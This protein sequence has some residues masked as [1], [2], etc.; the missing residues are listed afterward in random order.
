MAQNQAYQED[1]WQGIV[2][3]QWPPKII[4]LVEV[5][6][7][8]V[9]TKVNPTE[10]TNAPVAELGGFLGKTIPVSTISRYGVLSIK[11]TA[12]IPS[13]LDLRKFWLVNFS[14]VKRAEIRATSLGNDNRWR[15]NV[16]NGGVFAQDAEGVV[17]NADGIILWRSSIGE[18]DSTAGKLVE[19][20]KDGRII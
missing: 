20:D 19:F 7:L 15:I 1:P 13:I 14:K 2:N 4:G 5:Q 17:S 18:P 9:N 10:P 3:V 16:Y 6:S 12:K 11:D 8:V